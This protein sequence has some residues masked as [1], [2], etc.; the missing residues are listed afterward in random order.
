MIRVYI[1]LPDCN[2]DIP[3]IVPFM[4]SETKSR[5]SIM[6]ILKLLYTWY[7]WQTDGQ[8]TCMHVLVIAVFFFCLSRQKFYIPSAACMQFN[9]SQIPNSRQSATDLCFP[10]KDATARKTKAQVREEWKK[11][12]IRSLCSSHSIQLVLQV[13]PIGQASSKCMILYSCAYL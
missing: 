2:L 12:I 4:Q 5:S 7:I 10:F 6:A 13:S 8:S 9:Q 3:A 11:A 1:P